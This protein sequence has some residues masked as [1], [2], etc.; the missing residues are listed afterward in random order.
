MLHEVDLSRA[1]LNLLVVFEAVLR[2][3]H[4][5]RAG[6]RLSLSP[7]AVS[8]GLTRLRRMLNDPLF[9]RTPKGV[10]PTARALELAPQVAEVLE[11]A[12]RVISAGAPFDPA[13]S[14]RRF[15]IGTPDAEATLVLP[16]L[17]AAVA[18]LAPGVDLSVRTVMPW[19][20]LTKLDAGE[21][22]VAVTPWAG[23]LPKRFQLEPLFPQDFVIAMRRGHPL[24]RTPTLDVYCAHPHAVMSM[25]GD[26]SGFV[27]E[28]LAALGR[29]RRIALTLPSFL[30][31]LSALE[32]GDLVAAVP[33]TMVERFAERF[34][35]TWV[36]PPLEL[37]DAVICAVA[38]RSA[39][40]DG[41]VAWLIERLREAYAGEA[42]RP[43]TASVLRPQ[44]R[45]RP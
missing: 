21:L 38:T 4:V 24:A 32:A 31:I 30:S 20:V 6:A 8:H 43:A 28:R 3:Q 45:R 42:A 35:L 40:R 26:P 44:A 36:E 1:D 22:D 41:G 37:V 33:R 19:D 34:G 14:A 39:L 5:G 25:T 9:L 11:A 15:V 16:N 18:R 10:R 29:R 7:S 13:T 23:E 17:P 27:D 2:E 12:R